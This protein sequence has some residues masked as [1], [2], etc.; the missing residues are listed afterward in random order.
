MKENQIN[1]INI[2]I[3]WLDKYYLNKIKLGWDTGSKVW[4]YVFDN[5]FLGKKILSVN[6]KVIY[7]NRRKFRGYE[8]EWTI[9]SK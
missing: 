3:A 4:L 8:K 1:G 2:D 9:K 6:K 7:T 5:V